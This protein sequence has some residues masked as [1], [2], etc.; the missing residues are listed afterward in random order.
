[1][2]WIRCTYDWRVVRHLFYHEHGFSP[3]VDV[4]PGAVEQLAKNRVERLRRQSTEDTAGPHVLLASTS[5]T[6][7]P[8]PNS[9]SHSPS[10]PS[11]SSRYAST[12]SQHLCRHQRDQVDSADSATPPTPTHGVLRLERADEPSQ[13]A[14]HPLLLRLTLGDGREQLGVLAPVRRELG[15]RHGGQDDWEEVSR[16]EQD[17]RFCIASRWIV[18]A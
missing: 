3:S 18:T 9:N 13:H 4:G 7:L 12:G 6:P 8:L 11:P 16:A 10:S 15:E 2:R 17:S 5:S 14:L 1:M